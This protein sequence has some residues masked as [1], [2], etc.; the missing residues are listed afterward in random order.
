MSLQERPPNLGKTRKLC[1]VVPR[2]VR[3][4]TYKLLRNLKNFRATLTLVD[5]GSSEARTLLQKSWLSPPLRAALVYINGTSEI[6][7]ILADFLIKKPSMPFSLSP[8]GP[9]IETQRVRTFI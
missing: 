9:I 6:S 8:L 5:Q 1:L 4:R 3:R 2:E 7:L